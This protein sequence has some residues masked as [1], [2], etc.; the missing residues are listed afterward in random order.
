[1]ECVSSLLV[2]LE[3]EL[4]LRNYSDKTK[5][6]YVWITND[7]LKSSDN[8]SIEDAK[9]YLLKSIDN[10]MSSSSIKLRYSALKILF[11]SNNK[12]IEF[13]LP[14][15]KTESKLPEV[16]NKSEVRNIIQSIKNPKHKLMIQILY[17]AGLRC[18]ELINLRSKD[19]DIERNVVMIREGKGKKD[20]ISLLSNSIKKD[21][22]KYLLE[23]SP[24]KCLFESN[25]GGKYSAKSIQKIVKNASIK[26]IGRKITPHT[27]RHSFDTHLLEKGID[28]RKIQK[29]LG[30][31]NLRT[32][33]IYT[34]VANVDLINIKNP[35]D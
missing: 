11:S 9:E 1:M 29:L 4:K 24:K 32:T 27:L 19:I 21:L 34:H 31:K 20:R 3:K 35:L 5:K 25:R 17:S 14:P 18:S 10:K 2:N 12:K 7:F 13:N 15:Y 33:K 22:L 28:L 16:I 23:H 26:V 30:Y 8:L 6:S